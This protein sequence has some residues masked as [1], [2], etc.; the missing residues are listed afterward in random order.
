MKYQ[1]FESICSE[2]EFCK[3]EQHW[4]GFILRCKTEKVAH[5][6]NELLKQDSNYLT[7]MSHD[8]KRLT[9]VDI[10][11]FE[12][13]ADGFMGKE[14]QQHLY[15]PLFLHDLISILFYNKDFSENYKIEFLSGRCV[16]YPHE[17]LITNK[18]RIRELKEEAKEI[19]AFID[20]L[21]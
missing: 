20:Q 15:E 14:K 7:R 8:Q 1:C 16:N 5:K 9:V 4:F 12:S 6:A 3:K 13:W 10:K 19:D 17:I 11:G 18:K 21:F 2:K